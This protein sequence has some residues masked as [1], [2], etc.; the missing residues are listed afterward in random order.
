MAL[1]FGIVLLVM[2]LF[3]IL[4]IFMVAK[5]A[6]GDIIPSAMLGTMVIMFTITGISIINDYCSPRITPIDVYRGRTT[7]EI[8]YRDSIAIDSISSMEG[9]NKI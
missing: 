7:L 9:G 1:F 3:L 5:Q 8:T 6:D 2:S 4:L